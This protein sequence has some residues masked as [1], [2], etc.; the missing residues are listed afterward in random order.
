M[1]TLS[2]RSLRTGANAYSVST[3]RGHDVGD[4]GAST[5]QDDCTAYR[6]LPRD[7]AGGLGASYQD[8][9]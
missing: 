1:V 7:V 6:G 4:I 8:L 2:V 9:A 5:T 3:N